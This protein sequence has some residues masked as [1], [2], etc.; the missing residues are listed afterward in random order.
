M[1]ATDLASRGRASA[2][3]TNIRYGM[4][5]K[6]GYRFSEKIMLQQYVRRDDASWQG[7]PP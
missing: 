7:H 1:I 6:S 2:M 4:I 5:P 3:L